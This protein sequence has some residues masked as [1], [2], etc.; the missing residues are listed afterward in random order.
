MY[1]A[2]PGMEPGISSKYERSDFLRNQLGQW[3]ITV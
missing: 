3:E 1:V 2:G